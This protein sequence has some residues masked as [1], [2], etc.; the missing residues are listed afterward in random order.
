MKMI[1][2]ADEEGGIGKD[3][4][5]PWYYPE[6]LRFLKFMTLHKNIVM[7]RKTFENIGKLSDR[8]MY[9]LSKEKSG[10]IGDDKMAKY[11]TIE[12]LFLEAFNSEREVYNCG[13]AEIYD[14]FL[15]RIEEALITR[16]EGTYDCDTFLPDI[17]ERLTKVYELPLNEDL[18]VERWIE[19]KKL[20]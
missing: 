16:V 18:T 7:G 20:L 4:G 8:K 6:D 13:G 17:S 14:L 12:D 15:D 1:A 10:Y 5:I 19:N 9:I 11:V 3:G 2:A